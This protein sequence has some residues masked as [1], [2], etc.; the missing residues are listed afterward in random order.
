MEKGLM[1]LK[2]VRDYTGWSDS[3][4]R[5]ILRNPKHKFNLKCGNRLYVI[6]DQFISY[7]ENCGKFQIPVK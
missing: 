6:K 5:Q 2:E 1:N 4:A 7:L 3:F